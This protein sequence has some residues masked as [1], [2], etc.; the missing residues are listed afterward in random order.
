LV[1]LLANDAGCTSFE[2]GGTLEERHRLLLADEAAIGDIRNDVL[3]FASALT[4]ASSCGP[5]P[6]G[7]A[8]LRG[9]P[10]GG[11]GQR[12]DHGEPAAGGVFGFH[13]AAHRLG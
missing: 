13:G 12:E 4:P 6:R 5:Y 8:G 1:Y 11:G 2:A 7:A 9:G 10:G 3:M